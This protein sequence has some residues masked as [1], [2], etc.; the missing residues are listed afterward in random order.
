[1]FGYNEIFDLVGIELQDTV[2]FLEAVK[3]A[4]LESEYILMFK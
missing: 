3:L 1:V 4:W 2:V